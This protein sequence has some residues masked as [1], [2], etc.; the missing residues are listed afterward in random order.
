[1]IIVGVVSII[2]VNNHCYYGITFNSAN[3]TPLEKFEL[4]L[5]FPFNILEVSEKNQSAW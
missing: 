1:M 5:R 3:K 2:H 4:F